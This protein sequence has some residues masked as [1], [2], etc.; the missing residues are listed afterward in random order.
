MKFGVLTFGYDTFT[1]FQ[2]R[3][4]KFGFT[5]VN[6]GDNA[7]TI[8]VRYVYRQLGIPDDKVVDV[9]RDALISYDGDPVYLMMNGVFSKVHFPLSPKITPLFVGFCATK[10]AIEPNVADLRDYE[11]VIF[12]RDNDTAEI[13]TSFGFNSPV[14]GCLTLSLPERETIPRSP[15]T[16]IVY[17][18]KAGELP[19]SLLKHIPA[20]ILDTAE[21]ISNRLVVSEIPLSPAMMKHA[22]RYEQ[23]LMNR[24]RDEATL[25]ITPLHHVAAPCI[26][27]GIPTIIA[28]N[29]VGPRFSYLKTLTPIY[30]PETFDNIDWKPSLVDLTVPRDRLV[31]AIMTQLRRA[32]ASFVA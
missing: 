25:I 8:A 16:F 11:S 3:A 31:D 18:Q 19:P 2:K 1:A 10:E 13:L 14:S 6:L 24:F 15:K 26:A 27:M 12:C 29:D 23:H 21:F 32:G 30:T 20:E 4:S 17:G 28:R 7:Q 9:N 22:E 5:T